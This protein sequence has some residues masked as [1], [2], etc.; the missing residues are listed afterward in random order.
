MSNDTYVKAITGIPLGGGAMVTIGT[1]DSVGPSTN[2]LVIQSDVLYAQSAS[3]TNPGMLSAADKTSLDSVTASQIANTIY[4]GPGSSPSASPTFR[5]LVAADLPVIPV[6]QGG[7]G[8]SSFALGSIVYSNGTA[9]TENNANLNW[10]DAD[11]SLTIV[12]PSTVLT[13][14]N[15]LT[16]TSDPSGSHGHGN[17]IAIDGNPSGGGTIFRT[18]GGLNSSWL[19]LYGGDSSGAN[20]GQIYI[21][22]NNSTDGDAGGVQLVVG[23]VGA[24]F[25]ILDPSYNT[26][27]GVT[28][29][30]TSAGTINCPI[31]TASEMVVT[32]SS[33]NLV[34]LAY[35]DIP[36]TPAVPGN[37]TVVPTSIAQALDMIAAKLSPV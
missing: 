29:S 33:S 35:S 20:S 7:T 19:Q 10:N 9:L 27:F 16:V 25:Q 34:S 22:G 17:H 12:Q 5:P 23:L 2:A 15:V 31:L 3:T 28:C 30:A 36:Y 11:G 6:A 26:L 21:N 1:I 37:W 32:D 24:A 18:D 14:N 8:S 4:A 13:L